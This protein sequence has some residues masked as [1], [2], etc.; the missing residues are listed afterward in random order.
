MYLSE[1][2]F[3]HGVMKISMACQKNFV[4]GNNNSLML[5]LILFLDKF[6]CREDL[7]YSGWCGMFGRRD[8]R[9]VGIGINSLWE[10]RSF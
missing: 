10:T 2:F 4:S 6:P 8:L 7:I 3:A 1:M 9:I 5:T